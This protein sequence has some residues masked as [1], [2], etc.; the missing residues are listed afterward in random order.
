MVNSVEKGRIRGFVSPEN[1]LYIT[2][3]DIRLALQAEVD[4]RVVNPPQRERSGVKK[5]L[6]EGDGSRT[7]YIAK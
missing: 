2:P 6:P 3:A 7:I 5:L 4:E 1:G